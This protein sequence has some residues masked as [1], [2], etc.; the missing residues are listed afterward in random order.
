MELEQLLDFKWSIMTPEFIILGVATLLSILDLF[1]P[2]SMDRKILGWI[3]VAGIAAATVSLAG[4]IDE[5]VTSILF[6]TFRLDS[7]AKAF[8]FILLIGSLFVLL[9]AISFEKKDGLAEFAGEFYYLFLTALLGAM[10]M[11]SSGDLITLFIGL[12]LLTIS[13]WVLVGVTKRNKKSNESAMKYVING[14]IST[15]ITLFGLS[16]IYGLTGT[17]NIKDMSG[18]LMTM[19]GS[20][21]QLYLLAIAFF[22]TL[23]GLS[24]KLATAPFHMWAPDVYEGA[25]TPVTAFLSIVSKTAGFVIIVRIFVS[26]FGS[27]PATG[28]QD[29]LPM[30]LHLQDYIGFLAG[31]T[32]IIGNVIALR[33]RN[34]KRMF[35][36]SSIA[37]AGYI[38]VAFTSMSYFTF[39]AIWFYLL[40]YLFMNVGA[41]A[42]IQLVGAKAGS[43]DISAYAG[44]YRR[45]PILAVTFAVLILSLAGIPG[46]AGFIGKLNI[47]MGAFATEPAH[48]VLAS[49]LIATS[50]VSYFYYFGIMTQMFFRPAAD[51]SKFNIP[52]AL[53]VVLIGSVVGTIALGIL[54]NIAFDFLHDNFMQ[55]K[56]FLQ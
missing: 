5:P 16:Y 34:I 48:Y 55:F 40:A 28:A 26:I 53:L 15:A 7:F 45:A 36:Y 25:P 47:F 13:S 35:A 20:Q 46:T 32:M 39:D 22:M 43:D 14:G 50:V 42:I 17:T 23:V 21:N 19:G 29:A 18:T 6:D 11:A 38:L 49:I 31:A 2:K 8:K 24:F 54:P 37:H 10:F 9:L 41:F 1:M 4:F 44:L 3:G 12:E 56:D 27:V 30:L 52:V 33:Q 51:D